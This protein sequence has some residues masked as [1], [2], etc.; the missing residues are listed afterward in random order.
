MMYLGMEIDSGGYL[1]EVKNHLYNTLSGV[2][3]IIFTSVLQTC[4]KKHHLPK[5]L[6]VYKRSLFL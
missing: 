3:K 6:N 5:K 4:K 2:F 1:S